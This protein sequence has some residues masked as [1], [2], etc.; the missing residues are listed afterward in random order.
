MS[1]PQEA[2]I[3]KQTITQ[4]HL[5]ECIEKQTLKSIGKLA[6]ALKTDTGNGSSAAPDMLDEDVV[7]TASVPPSGENKAV[8]SKRSK[9]SLKHSYKQKVDR[10]GKG[11][12]AKDDGRSK[13]TKKR[14]KFY[15][16]F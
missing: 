8:V 9:K 3:E 4:N 16:Q 12:N 2:Y 11:R 14:P 6:D 13:E 7:T 10:R 15:C 5:K 1:H